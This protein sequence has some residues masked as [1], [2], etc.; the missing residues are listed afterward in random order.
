M[1]T[2]SFPPSVFQDPAYRALS[3]HHRYGLLIL[4][5][6]TDSAGQ[7]TKDQTE[8]AR[9]LHWSPDQV[10]ALLVDLHRQ[11]WLQRG[12]AGQPCYT[13]I[14]KGY[15]REQAASSRAEKGDHR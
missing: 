12:T 1:T 15:I 5:L 13:L 14:R 9:L 6:H 8:L 11:G 10:E 4:L 2:L 7:A 3:A